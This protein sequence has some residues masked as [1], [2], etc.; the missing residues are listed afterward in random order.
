M[1]DEERFRY[2]HV[3]S[4]MTGIRRSPV[5]SARSAQKFGRNNKKKKRR[6]KKKMKRRNG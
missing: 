5:S 4:C 3:P 2:F 6:R 1:Y